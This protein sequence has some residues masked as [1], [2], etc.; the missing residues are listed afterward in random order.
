V[1]AFAD[2]TM[3]NFLYSIDGL[4]GFEYEY[5]RSI[6]KRWQGLTVPILPLIRILKSKQFI[7]REKDLAHIPLLKQTIR[8]TKRAK[9]SSRE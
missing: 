5:K 8:L 7:A 6:K 3:I 2:G 9:T 1:S 4:R